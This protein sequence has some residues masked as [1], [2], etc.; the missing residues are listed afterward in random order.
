MSPNN[1]ELEITESILMADSELA[2]SSLRELADLGI[3]LA[4][5]DFGTGYSSL[6]Y[7][8]QFPLNVLKIDRSFVRDVTEDA[9]DAAIVDAILAMSKRLQLDVVAEGVESSAQLAFLQTHGCQRVQG[10]Y[11]SKPLALEDLVEFIE[12][13]EIEV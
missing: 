9:D 10:Y 3:T 8:K 2:V 11:F 7:L 6:S 1:L 13:G 4:V 12:Y 5:D